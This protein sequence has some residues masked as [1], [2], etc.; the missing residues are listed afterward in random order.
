MTLRGSRLPCRKL[1][2]DMM[3]IARQLKLEVKPEGVTVL[4]ESHDKT[5]MYD[6]LL[7]MSEQRKRFLELKSTPDE[8]L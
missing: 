1:T 6:E 4:P 3:E 8:V 2:A 7:L 5:L